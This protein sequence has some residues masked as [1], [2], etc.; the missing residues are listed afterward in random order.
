MNLKSFS[1]G[2]EK[3]LF[4]CS[5]CF[6]LSFYHLFGQVNY[7]SHQFFMSDRET[8]KYSQ[9]KYSTVMNIFMGKELMDLPF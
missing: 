3:M 8:G 2:A 1:G 7:E 4:V 5:S 9:K 6:F